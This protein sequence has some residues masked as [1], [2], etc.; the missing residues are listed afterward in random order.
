MDRISLACALVAA[1]C[2]VQAADR[3]AVAAR[4][5][6][7]CATARMQDDEPEDID[8]TDTTYDEAFVDYARSVRP[9][10]PHLPSNA[11]F[12]HLIA[13]LQS[14]DVRGNMLDAVH[15][16]SDPRL[17]PSLLDELPRAR[18]IQQRDG[19]M[20]AIVGAAAKGAWMPPEIFD[21]LFELLDATSYNHR[22][23]LGQYGNP[24]GGSLET[25]VMALSAQTRYASARGE[26]IRR[27]HDGD[28]RQQFLCAFVLARTACLEEMDALLAYWRPHLEDN[29]ISEDGRWARRAVTGLGEPALPTL[30][31]W[32]SETEDE[33][34]KRYIDLIVVAIHPPADDPWAGDDC[35]G[36]PELAPGPWR[37]IA[38]VHGQPG[39][40]PPVP[41]ALLAH[42]WKPG[43]RGF[44]DDVVAASS[45]AS[46]VEDAQVDSDQGGE[47]SADIATN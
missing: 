32:R 1:A 10:L 41:T 16:L 47:P 40:K 35:R 43:N 44:D 3:A 14:D 29:A 23:M 26:L 22:T 28:P 39:W 9:P 38:A 36:I 30:R 37:V 15:L 6:A 42:G 45:D 18:D 4:A 7:A 20:V 8:D 2:I 12:V 5:A 11:E 33:Q 25:V 46:D 17:M 19:I 13:N 31:A 24:W 27:F 21:D 34:L